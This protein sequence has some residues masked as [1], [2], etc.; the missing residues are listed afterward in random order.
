MGK[1]ALATA[2]VMK[3][4]MWS[5][6]AFGLYLA[7]RLAIDGRVGFALLIVFILIPIALWAVGLV[8]AVVYA[9]VLY[10]IAVITGR[11]REFEELTNFKIAAAENVGAD[12]LK[13]RSVRLLT[14][15]YEE[16]PPSAPGQPARSGDELIALYE[17]LHPD[18]EYA[19]D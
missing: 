3:L 16:L 15:M 7:L 14:S 1:A 5:L 4:I 18:E 12:R 8:L 9:A 2:V 19:S 10:P 6:I 17:D 13:L 11:R